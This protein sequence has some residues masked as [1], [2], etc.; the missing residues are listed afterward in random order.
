[1]SRMKSALL[2]AVGVTALQALLV[3]LFA[4]PAAKT[5]PRDLPVVVAGPA[6]GAQALAAQLKSARPGAFQISTVGDGPSA[7]TALRER[8]AYA[9]FVLDATGVSL[10]VASAAS[11]TTAILLEQAAAGIAPAVRVLDVVPTAPADP[12]GS[13]F[14]AG[15]LPLVMTSV[16]AGALLYLLVLVPARRAEE[17]SGAGRR[18]GVP[19]ALAGLLGYALLAGAAGALVLRGWLGILGGGYLPD[20]AVIALF[21]LAA[22]AGV[23]G[24][25]ALAGRAGLGLGV[26]LVFLAGNSLSGAASAPQLLPQPWGQVGQWLPPGAGATLLRS[27]AYFSGHGGFR[28]LWVLGAWAVAGLVL[29]ALAPSRAASGRPP[30]PSAD[31]RPR[32]QPAAHLG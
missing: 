23:A 10:H 22:S 2:V 29:V 28:A 31:T 32:P 8:R 11:P 19:G 7:D 18:A 30:A 24:L 14:A 5:A 21:A 16:L 13:G 1:M 15:L 9:A 26:L 4:E 20:A 3:P 6:A 25:A 17:E 12:R 27:V